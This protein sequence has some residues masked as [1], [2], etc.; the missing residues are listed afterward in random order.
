MFA[1]FDTTG[2]RIPLSG[3]ALLAP[4]I[5]RSRS[6]ASARTTRSRRRDGRRG[7][8]RAADVPQAEHL[9]DRSERRDRASH[10]PQRADDYEGELAVVI[11]RIAKNVPAE[12]AGE[13]I[14]GY[15]VANDVTARDLQRS[16]GQWSRAKGFDTFCPVG[17]VIETDL[18]L[19]TARIVTGVNGEV[20]QD[21]PSPTWSTTSRPSSRTRARCSPSCGR[22]D[23]HRHPG[24]FIGSF[25]ARA[26]SSRSRSTAS[27]CCATR[28]R[29]LTSSRGGRRPRRHT[30]PHRARAGGGQVLTG[31]GLRCD[32]VARR[33]ARRGPLGER[34]A[35]GIRDRRRHAGC[36]PHTRFRWRAWP[37]DGVGGSRSR[38]GISPPSSVSSSSS[39]PRRPACSR[40]C[41]PESRSSA[42][43]RRE[44]SSPG[45]PRPIWRHTARRGR[46]LATVVWAT[47][48]GGVVGPLLLARA[49]LS[50]RHRDAAPHGAYLFSFAA[51]AC[52]FA[53]Y[54]LVLRPDPL[55]LASAW[56]GR[57]RHP[58]RRCARR[59]SCARAVRDVRRCRVPRHDGLGDDGDD[60]GCTCRT[61]WPRM[62]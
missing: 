29:C 48:V 24:R 30:A 11:G 56:T 51:Q 15:T 33:P 43:Q 26:T 55:L 27:G 58:H 46:D 8:R 20:R 44:P 3:V 18:D 6:S 10:A 57:T 23:P 16:D 19:G 28:A 42:R 14:F 35:L 37:V 12:R 41:S 47:T 60:A 38:R 13:Y 32:A 2:E 40:C 21:G 1:G 49:K 31:V 22:P 52:A 34:G 5:P 61:S 45:S 17:P 54:T 53:L 62:P 50:E 7:P 9:G 4:V 39:R 36:G 25:G 59:S